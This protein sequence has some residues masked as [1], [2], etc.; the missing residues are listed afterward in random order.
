PRKY[1]GLEVPPILLG[2]NFP[3]IEKWREEQ[4]MER[5][6]EKRPDLLK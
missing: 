1:K 5:T 6:K 2:G 3:E 4:A